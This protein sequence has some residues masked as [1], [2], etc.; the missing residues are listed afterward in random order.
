MEVGREYPCAIMTT[1][2]LLPI[3]ATLLV[4]DHHS[5]VHVDDERIQRDAVLSKALLQ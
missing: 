4:H 2:R 1:M 3:T 5:P